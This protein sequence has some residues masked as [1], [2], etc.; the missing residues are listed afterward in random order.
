LQSQ[1]K[2]SPASKAK[3]VPRSVWVG[4]A[5]VWLAAVLGGF[6]RI[7]TYANV[8]GP[9]GAPPDAWPVA[10][11]IARDAGAP[12]LLVFAHPQ[13][14]CSHATVGELARLMAH[15]QGRLRAH[16]LMYR[17]VS[18]P[19]SWAQGDMWRLAAAIPGVSVSLDVDGV[20]SKRFGVAV[21]GHTLVYDE[22]GR[23]IFS[24]GITA[25]RGHEGDNDGRLAIVSFL[26]TH[27]MAISRT[28][29]FGCFLRPADES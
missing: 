4:L 1:E 7:G 23:L 14:P 9:A 21:S 26:E 29:V 27:A 12:T 8:A 17:P 20:E 11:A 28:P 19:I 25:S 5:I 18:E 6:W 22:H 16:V 10:S 2:L 13:C 24:G 15:S 3:R